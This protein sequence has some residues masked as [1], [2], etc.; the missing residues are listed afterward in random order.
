M[1]GLPSIISRFRNMFNKI[2]STGARMSD[3]IYYLTVKHGGT[4]LVGH[5]CYLCRPSL[6]ILWSLYLSTHS[7]C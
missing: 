4:S 3:S 6:Y 5:L 2:N 1:L 7:V